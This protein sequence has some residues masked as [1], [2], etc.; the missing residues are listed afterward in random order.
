MGRP[1]PAHL[2]MRD[3]LATI[4]NVTVTE[5]TKVAGHRIDFVVTNRYGDS[6]GVDVNGDRWHRWAKVRECD[7]VKLNRVFAP[8]V[9]PCVLG[10]WWSRLQRS[11]EFVRQ[12]VI[13][14][15]IESRLAWWDWAVRVDELDEAPSRRVQSL[16]RPGSATG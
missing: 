8:S 7:R 15:V 16:L 5:E 13:D 6:L 12:A 14:G 4:P 1:S 3:L 2:A 10:V 9:R 11:P